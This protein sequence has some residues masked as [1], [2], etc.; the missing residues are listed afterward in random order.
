MHI[1]NE[2]ELMTR[3]ALHNYPR[4]FA[5]SQARKLVGLVGGSGRFNGGELCEFPAKEKSV[6]SRR[7]FG[8]I[9]ASVRPKASQRAFAVYQ[10]GGKGL[11]DIQPGTT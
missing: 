4:V 9:A 3:T 10:D 7:S 1:R 5:P 11:R 6:Y 2:K 8:R